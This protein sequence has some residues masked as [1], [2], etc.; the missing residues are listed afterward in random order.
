MT[1]AEDIYGDAVGRLPSQFKSGGDPLTYWDAILKV[2]APEAQEVA[3]AGHQLVED[4]FTDIAYGNTLD[5][6]GKLLS[7][8]RNS[9]LDND[10]R[11]VMTA[12]VL[13]NRSF[14]TVEFLLEIAARLTQSN[15]IRAFGLYPMMASIE[16]IVPVNLTEGTRERLRRLLQ[17]AGL[18][19]VKVKS[20]ESL[21]NGFAFSGDSEGL[22]FNDGLLAHRVDNV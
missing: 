18:G 1:H 6:Y 5:F 11:R 14:G 10:Y 9:L 20:I 16:S 15:K 19:G 12:K 3:D 7:E 22:G 2:V 13:S 17:R 8:S 21:N 4:R